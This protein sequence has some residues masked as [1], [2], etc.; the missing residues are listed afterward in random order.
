MVSVSVGQVVELGFFS[1]S[2]LG[3]GRVLKG[4]F[5]DPQSES[6]EYIW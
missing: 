1:G 2:G 6:K 4:G 5:V 3:V